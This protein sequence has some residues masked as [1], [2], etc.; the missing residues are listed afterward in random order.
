MS[1]QARRGTKSEKNTREHLF[2][3]EIK[4][5]ETFW[6][7]ISDIKYNNQDFIQKYSLVKDSD[8]IEVGN[9]K[10]Y[11]IESLEK[12][13]CKY[14]PEFY[15]KLEKEMEEKIRI[16]KENAKEKSDEEHNKILEI[17]NI[18]KEKK[19]NIERYN[20][21]I[22]EFSRKEEELQKELHEVK[23]NKKE[24]EKRKHKEE[25]GIKKLEKE[26]E[27][28]VNNSKKIDSNKEAEITKVKNHY[29]LRSRK[30]NLRSK[31]SN[32]DI[33]TPENV[34]INNRKF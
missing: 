14:E 26:N 21:D 24:A 31:E 4:E 19:K 8:Y 22:E 20:K 25:K 1:S 7:L 18:H 2:L 30:S 15:E 23:N 9:Q 3:K 10:I 5:H 33:C 16:I 28:C 6:F 32:I 12:L 13:R 29:N 34:K 11:Y 17:R 27:K